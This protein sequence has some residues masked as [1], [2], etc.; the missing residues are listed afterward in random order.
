SDPTSCRNYVWCKGRKSIVLSCAQ[1]LYFD[2]RSGICTS[3]NDT[4]C[5]PGQMTKVPG[6]E[7]RGYLSPLSE[8]FYQ[9]RSEE[10]KVVCYFSSWAW[11]RPDQGSFVPENVDPALC[12]HIIYA[13]AILDPTKLEIRSPDTWTDLDNN[14]YQRILILR[15]ANPNLRVLLGL[16][17]WTD[18]AGDKY[19]RLVNNPDARARF[20]RHT[21]ALLSAYGFDGLDLHWEYPVCWQIDCKRGPATD[22]QGFAALVR[23][24]RQ[25]FIQQPVPFL[26]SAA[27]SPARGIISRAYDIRTLSANLDFFN[28]M[29]YDYHG[30]WEKKTGHISPLLYRESDKYESQNTDFSINYLIQGGA[31]PK[32]LVMGI[33]FYGQTF[34]LA[35]QSRN[36]LNDE[37]VGP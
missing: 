20:V 11:L 15:E 26:L 30:F 5:I 9:T 35:D 21:V 27:V 18:S 14:F 2:S 24:L 6:G 7:H 25:V 23:E 31:D 37:V 28:V 13:F 4:F 22:K 8:T 34:T 16:G 36:S 32:K 10:Y 19:S 17:G 1:D 29:S 33:P 12:T 3:I